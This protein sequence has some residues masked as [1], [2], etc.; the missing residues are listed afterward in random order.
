MST[1]PLPTVDSLLQQS[2][3]ESQL[4]IGELRIL[5]GH[6]LQLDKVGLITHDRD[7]VSAEN[8]SAFK[9]LVARRQQGEPIAYLTRIQEFY[10]RPFYVDGRVLIPRPETEELVERALHL[11]APT[12]RTQILTRVLD[13]GTGS[14]AIAITLA[15]ENPLLHI[16]ATDLSSDAL[17]VARYNAGQ[18]K[19]QHLQFVQSDALSD[20]EAHAQFDLIV[21]NPP[22]IRAH[23]PHLQQGDL[24]FEP[25]MALTDQ[26]DGL[27][28]YR[29]LA[30]QSPPRL[31]PHGA[32][33]VEH[34]FDHQTE[35]IQIFEQA[36]FAHVQGFADLAGN[37]R[38]VL[39]KLH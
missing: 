18:L 27:Q 22:Y 7:P 37:P 8:T 4:P 19:A 36:G 34:G 28:L 31:R 38:M 30:A 10:S 9:S 16:T 35:V 39:A 3:G 11:I 15:L 20:I 32:V 6:V 25:S 2:R 5:L 29:A 24:R 1:L 17:A 26:A 12:A 14:G 33:L 21:S 13:M 23:D